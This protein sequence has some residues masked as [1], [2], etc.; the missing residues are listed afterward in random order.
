VTY[1]VTNAPEV[2]RLLVQHMTIVFGGLI[3][4][5]IV[6]V[7]IGVLI[8]RVRVLEL[9]VMTAAG[10]LY[11]TPSLAL[12]AALIPITGLGKT[13]AIAAQVVYSLLVITRNTVTGLRSVPAPEQEA[14]R[15]LGLSGLQ[16]LWMVEIPSALP[17]IV[18]GIRVA[19]VMGVGIA[20]IAAYVGAGGL[21][22][23]VF[24]GIA[25]V[26]GSLIL[27]GV[28]PI[29]ALALSIDYSL[30]FIEVRLGR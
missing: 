30:R 8:S 11:I 10:L 28:L 3:L 7:P 2:L 17:I 14:A 29:T 6:G 27:A 18:G 26:D 23:L 22:S 16:R 5:I 19:A 1:L 24:R 9:P 25:T 4:S 15:G 13:T 20:S 12:F 21:G